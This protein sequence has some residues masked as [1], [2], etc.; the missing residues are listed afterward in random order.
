[1]C[2]NIMQVVSGVLIMWAVKKWLRF[3]G[4]GAPVGQKNEVTCF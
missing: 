2:K 3:L 1:M 4:G